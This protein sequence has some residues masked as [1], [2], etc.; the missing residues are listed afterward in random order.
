MNLPWALKQVPVSY[1]GANFNK[2]FSFLENAINWKGQNDGKRRK[3]VVIAI[4]VGIYNLT[5]DM[6][7]TIGKET[8]PMWKSISMNVMSVCMQ[9]TTYI[10]ILEDKK[11]VQY[12]FYSRNFHNSMNEYG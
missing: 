6:I 4:Q 2:F 5:H 12:Q 1:E 3:A 9:C 11:G 10:E 8:N 7:R